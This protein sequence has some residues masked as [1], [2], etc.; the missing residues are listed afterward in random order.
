M[1]L[2]SSSIAEAYLVV[3]GLIGFS[4][5]ISLF[6]FVETIVS[7]PPFLSVWWWHVTLLLVYGVLPIATVLMDSKQ[8]WLVVVTGASL[9]RISVEALGVFTWITNFHFL[10]VLL[11]ALAA[12]LSL[13]LAVEKVSVEVAAEMLCLEWSQF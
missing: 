11:N 2:R 1:K 8:S 10:F 13:K 3:F 12:V 5:V 9:I 4:H 6:G 7:A